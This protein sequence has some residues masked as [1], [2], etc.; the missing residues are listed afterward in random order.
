MNTNSPTITDLSIT[1]IEYYMDRYEHFAD[2]GDSELAEFFRSQAEE[3][4]HSLDSDDDT[5]TM[6]YHRYLSDS[7]GV[8]F[9]QDH[10]DPELY[11][12]GV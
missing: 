2:L 1:Q 12:G 7:F 9:E 4:A 3:L 10:G 5:L 6:T 11:F 8:V